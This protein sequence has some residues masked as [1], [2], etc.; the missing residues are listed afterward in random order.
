MRQAA[1]LPAVTPA[2]IHA[3]A[4]MIR[5]EYQHGLSTAG[6]VLL[7]SLLTDLGAPPAPAP[8]LAPERAALLEGVRVRGLALG[9][10]WIA[11]NVK[12]RFGH[13]VLEDLTAE[14][15]EEVRALIE[16]AGRPAA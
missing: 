8:E 4:T 10:K 11:E 13:A 15:L 6:E 9:A 16:Q 1:A 3:K 5:A 14:Q 12:A 7:L 2:E